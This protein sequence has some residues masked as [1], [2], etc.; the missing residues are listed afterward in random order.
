MPRKY[1]PT[2]RPP[3][4]PPRMENRFDPEK[5]EAMVEIV[6]QLAKDATGREAPELL[7]LPAKSV[8]EHN[9]VAAIKRLTKVEL[10][11]MAEATRDNITAVVAGFHHRVPALLEALAK[12]EPEKALKLYVE[13]LEYQTPK[14][15]RTEQT[16]QVNNN[17][18][19]FVESREERP[20]PIDVTPRGV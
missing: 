13:L 7:R 6:A 14:L 5:F 15:S 17:H 19:I 20:E 18:F 16:G 12:Y 1:V 9:Q 8:D 3:G 2:G 4:R 10:N 11:A